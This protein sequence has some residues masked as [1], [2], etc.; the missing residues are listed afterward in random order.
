VT[1]RAPLEGDLRFQ[2]VDA[3]STVNGYGN[4][5][6]G[7]ST[8]L[9][10]RMGMTFGSAIGTP[11]WVGPGGC[12]NP[13]IVDDCFFAFSEDPLAQSTLSFGYGSDLNDFYADDLQSDGAWVGSSLSG[14]NPSSSHS[15]IMSL[16]LEPASDLFALAWV[17]DNSRA[18]FLPTQQTVAPADLPAAA[19]AEGAAGRVITAISNNAGQITY[20]A[21]AWQS[22]TA[23]I[24]ETQIVSGS[25]EAAPGLAADLAA[26][27]YIIT[28]SGFA[29]DSYNVLL[30]GTRVQ[31]DTLA[32]PFV[33]AQGPAVITMRS[34]GY[35]TVAVIVNLQ[36]S[37]P[38]TFIGER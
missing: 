27:G 34:Q 19:A 4:A 17:E 7:L 15:V 24:Y 21:Y 12:G 36:A 37:N 9:N 20:F 25:A 38:Y 30:V 32:R 1:A 35:A 11:L 28:A 22:D 5:G 6:T 14:L 16:D 10:G 23:T 33:A 2:Q 29:D 18:G 3:D 13:P 26:Q 8:G 31:G